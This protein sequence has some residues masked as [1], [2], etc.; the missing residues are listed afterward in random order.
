MRAWPSDDTV[1]HL[2]F[3]D[4]QTLP[5]PADLAAA[6]EHATRKGARA[7]R[8]SA[9]FP[10]AAAIVLANG[11]EPIDRL[12]LLSRSIGESPDDGETGVRVRPMMPW[13]LTACSRIDRE[14]F[15]LLW[16][17]SPASL[18]DVRTA[19][20]LHRSRVA[21]VGRRLAGFALSG[22]AADTGYLQRLAV[23]PEHR[24]AGL[25]RGLVLD[26]LSWMRDR[27]LHQV[28]VNTGVANEPALRLYDTLGF[29]V[30]PDELT[31]AE[32]RLS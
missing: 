23:T 32:L 27:G 21:R 16:G 20:P 3:V 30:L 22:A 8:T 17:N 19:T 1:A 15:G 7:I 12:G 24:R 26:A 28:L 29:T 6:T 18:R 13:H 11:F 25:A 10:D 9:M 5:S 31:I 4:H 14:A 2:I